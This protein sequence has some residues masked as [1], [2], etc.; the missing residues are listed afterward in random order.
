MS[1][2]LLTR[3]NPLFSRP[4]TAVELVGNGNGSEDIFTSQLSPAVSRFVQNSLSC[5]T[6]TAYLSDL[7]HFENWGGDVP[8]S[9]ELVATYLATQA[10]TLQVATLVRRVAAI[11]KAHEARCLPNPTK[12][13]IVRA[14]MRGIKRSLGTAQKE[15]APLLRKDLFQVLSAMGDGIKDVRDRA[16]LLI[17]FAGGFRRSELVALNRA[18]VECVRQGLVITIRRAK[19]DQLGAG[20]KLAIAYG[21]TRHCPVAALEKWLEVAGIEEGAL[22]HRVDRHGNILPERLSGEAVS[23]VVK[24]RV[25][26]AEIEPSNYT[27]HS[28]RAGFAT[29][30]AQAGVPTHKIRAQTGHASDA[31]LARY[32]RDGSLFTE[33]A[34]DALL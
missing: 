28:L 19:T 27:G 30:A 23:M 22:F 25:A 29:S 2:D 34:T 32:I 5:A 26:A 8:A 9:A 15:A 16:L 4:T 14:T 12:S 18:D 7:R 21:R 10:E 31:M 33:N 24:E 13:E 3:H 11:S 6:R 20:R 17:G 1:V